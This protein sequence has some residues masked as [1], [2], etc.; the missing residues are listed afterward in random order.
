VAHTH[1]W[2]LGIVPYSWHSQS[3][4]SAYSSCRTQKRSFKAQNQNFYQFLAGRWPDAI[5]CQLNAKAGK[6]SREK[7]PCRLLCFLISNSL[8]IFEHRNPNAIE[9][10]IVPT[11]FL[12]LPQIH[13]PDRVRV[14]TGACKYQQAGRYFELD[15]Y[16]YPPWVAITLTTSGWI[17]NTTLKPSHAQ[18][19]A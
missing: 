14:S 2:R 9:H 19:Q 10:T 5:Y 15:W 1:W 18:D 3:T 4:H 7:S 6:P 16:I 12:Q 8:C 11:T 17:D 13:R